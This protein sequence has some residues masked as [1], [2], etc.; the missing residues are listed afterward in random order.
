MRVELYLGYTAKESK[1]RRS[2]VI[3]LL[4]LVLANPIQ[5]YAVGSSRWN[6]L[7]KAGSA[8]VEKALSAVSTKSGQAQKFAVFGKNKEN[9][10]A[11]RVFATDTK[12][13]NP[14]YTI[15][16]PPKVNF[17]GNIFEPAKTEISLRKVAPHGVE[18]D[19]IRIDQIDS[20]N[21]AMAIHNLEPSTGELISSVGGYQNGN[22]KY[23]INKSLD[24]KVNEFHVH[25]FDVKN[26]NPQSLYSLITIPKGDIVQSVRA[27]NV[28]K[29]GNGVVQLIIKHPN[30]SVETKAFGIVNKPQ[31]TRTS[32]SGLANFH[33]VESGDAGAH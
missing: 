14:I 9:G 22:Y 20:K 23:T 16:V 32:P 30:G 13:K 28:I 29:P 5:V 25:I 31:S 15:H 1:M 26:Y 19:I 8:L 18:S 6:I 4:S 17:G 27:A 11:I 24:P 33:T 7:N 2:S 12:T 21:G 10:Y 3:A